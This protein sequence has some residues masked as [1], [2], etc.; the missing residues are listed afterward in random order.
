MELIP[1]DV[2]KHIHGADRKTIDFLSD[3]FNNGEYV[4]AHTSGST[5]SPKTI[6]LPKKDMIVSARMTNRFFDI[7][8]NST[9]VCP[10]SPDYIAGK[11]MIVRAIDSGAQLF[12]EQPSNMP[13]KRDYGRIDLLPVVPSQLAGILSSDDKCRQIKALLIGGAKVDELMEEKIAEK[14]L[15]AFCSY[16]MTETCSHVALRKICN[17]NDIYTALGNNRFDVDRRGCLVIYNPDFSFGRLVTNDVVELTGP[18][19]FRWR[20]RIDNVINSGGIKVYPEIIETKIRP[21]IPTGMKYYVT[22]IPDKKWGHSPL[23]VIEGERFDTGALE[24]HIRDLV[25]PAER[26]SA[27]CFL[28]KFATTGNGKIRRI[29]PPLSDDG[30]KTE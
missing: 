17:G 15:N 23:L 28:K 22:S 1:T 9:I 7:N 24:D 5:G 6:M 30:V 27:I 26:P 18:S 29:V 14:G 11:M 2:L 8:A 13:L 25:D 12:M 16:G 20:G 3:W 21:C 4:K 10:L 19:E